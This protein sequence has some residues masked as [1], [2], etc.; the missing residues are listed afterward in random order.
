[1]ED[2]VKITFDENYRIRVLEAEKFEHT[3]QLGEACAAFVSKNQE[4]GKLVASVVQVVDANAQRIER[5]KL[6]AIGMRNLVLSERENRDQTRRALRAL[7]AEKTAELERYQRQHKALVQVEAD[8]K[9]R[10]ERL[11][12]SEP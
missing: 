5:E 7:V 2:E 11:S 8:L 12:N 6:K 1:M 9:S 3:E 4:F 10:I